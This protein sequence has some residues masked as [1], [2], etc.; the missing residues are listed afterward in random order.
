[1]NSPLRRDH[2]RTENALMKI[3]E[4]FLFLQQQRN[5]QRDERKEI[6]AGTGRMRIFPLP[7]K[8]QPVL[9]QPG[10][11]HCLLVGRVSEREKHDKAKRN[12]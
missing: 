10:P 3:R 11:V 7:A 12:A 6:E 5:R 4:R 2:T 8:L 9:G 1:M